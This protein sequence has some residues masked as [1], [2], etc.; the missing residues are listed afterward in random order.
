M[1][2]DVRDGSAHDERRYAAVLDALALDDR[3]SCVEPAA[4]DD[5]IERAAA[6][7]FGELRYDAVDSDARLIVRFPGDAPRLLA[8]LFVEKPLDPS[9]AAED[10]DTLAADLAAAHRRAAEARRTPYLTPRATP[11]VLARVDV[12]VG[13]DPPVLDRTLSALAAIAADVTG[14]H[15]TLVDRVRSHAADE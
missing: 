10:D 6:G 12:P 15:R 5:E 4:I 9:L 14:L 3:W 8:E 11:S 7:G 2:G 13:Y 1:E